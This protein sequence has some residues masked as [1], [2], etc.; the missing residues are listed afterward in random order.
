V[1]FLTSLTGGGVAASANP[2]AYG[3]PVTTGAKTINVGGNPNVQQAL[4]NPWLI[5]G[6]VLVAALYFKFRK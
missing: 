1:S 5:G 4:A 3:G 2:N 6:V